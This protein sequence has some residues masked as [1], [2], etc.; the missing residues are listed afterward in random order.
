MVPRAEQSTEVREIPVLACPVHKNC[1]G[2]Y[3]QRNSVL[4]SFTSIFLLYIL[5][6]I[7]VL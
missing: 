1:V 5:T 7:G 4:T 3:L 2:N 6:L